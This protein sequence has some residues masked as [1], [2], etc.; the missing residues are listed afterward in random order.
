MKQNYFKAVVTRLKERLSHPIF[1]FLTIWVLFFLLIYKI[2]GAPHNAPGFQGTFFL[3][4]IIATFTTTI[5]VVSTPKL[6]SRSIPWIVSTTVTCI[7][8]IH[9]FTAFH[10]G[11]RLY[12]ESDGPLSVRYSCLYSNLYEAINDMAGTEYIEKSLC[13]LR[14]MPLAA[15]NTTPYLLIPYENNGSMIFSIYE[16]ILITDFLLVTA[17]SKTYKK[18]KP[19]KK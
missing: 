18:A 3:S 11:P 6:R 4:Q 15:S 7:I 19:F 14:E 8:M 9:S 16:S 10:Y 1:L 5:I 17:L 2:E 12:V 13:W